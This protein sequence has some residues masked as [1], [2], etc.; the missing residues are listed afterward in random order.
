[1]QRVIGAHLAERRSLAI[2]QRSFDASGTAV[3][4]VSGPRMVGPEMPVALVHRG[5]RV[6]PAVK[7]SFTVVS[8][9]GPDEH[10]SADHRSF[11]SKIP[12]LWRQ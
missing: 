4:K 5:E 11:T 6:A 10:G 9:P 2:S 3:V 7:G 12:M 8:R 1:M